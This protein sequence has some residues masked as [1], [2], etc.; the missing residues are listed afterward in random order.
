MD[1]FHPREKILLIIVSSFMIII[2]FMGGYFIYVNNKLTEQTIIQKSKSLNSKYITPTPKEILKKDLSSSLVFTDQEITDNKL[3]LVVGDENIFYKDYAIEILNISQ[4]KESNDDMKKQAL[5]KL[6]DDSTLI[7]Y[8]ISKGYIKPPD[9]TLYN[10][11]DKH[12]PQRLDLIMQC[13]E[14]ISINEFKKIS[15]N[16]LKITFLNI[17]SE[18]MSLE[19][20]KEIIAKKITNIYTDV[21]NGKTSIEKAVLDLPKDPEFA[22]MPTLDVVPTPIEFDTVSNKKITDSENFDQLIWE[23]PSQ[24]YTPIFHDTN[25]GDKDAYMFAF[26][27]SK[28]DTGYTSMADFYQKNGALYEVTVY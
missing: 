23:T 25:S 16:G 15:G 5:Q 10:S 9:M 4:G 7:Q 19:N 24:T 22:K 27:K 11:P 6:I 8:N 14:K 26:I 21:I 1:S 12:Y 20:G 3:I 17:K 18:N 2:F 13:E 28:T